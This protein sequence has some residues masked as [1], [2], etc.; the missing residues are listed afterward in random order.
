MILNRLLLSFVSSAFMFSPV[1]MASET[2]SVA[3]VDFNQVIQQSAYADKLKTAHGAFTKKADALG[4]EFKS[5]QAEYTAFKK[6]STT[7]SKK[8]QQ[9]QEKI[10]T[11]KQ[12]KLRAKE[13]EL[14]KEFLAQRDSLMKTAME[15][16]K[17]SVSKIAASN[18]YT[19][20]VNKAESLYN[21]DNIDITSKVAKDIK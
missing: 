16:V 5:L 4:K 14:Q 7:M 1:A 21:T 18:H 17:A 10:L 13:M 19:L 15:R 8:E 11:A 3:V 9:A 12:N 2:S 6:K 20:V